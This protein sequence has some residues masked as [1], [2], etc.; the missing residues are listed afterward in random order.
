MSMVFLTIAVSTG[1][2]NY[3]SCSSSEVRV[4][5]PGF[6]REG[7]TLPFRSEAEMQGGQREVGDHLRV[8]IPA[9]CN[10]VVAGNAPRPMDR[11]TLAEQDLL[12][13]ELPQSRPG[14]IRYLTRV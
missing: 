5:M 8:E 6:G 3:G 9:R 13:R 2:R 1:I 4:C 10:D 7:M 12:P 14:R 11:G